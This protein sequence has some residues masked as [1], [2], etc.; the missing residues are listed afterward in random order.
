MAYVV[1]VKTDA[2]TQFTSAL[3]VGEQETENVS[4]AAIS[5]LPQAPCIVKAI[6]V[7]SVQNLA[8]DLVFF[9]KD[10]FQ[11][12]APN[13][14]YFVARIAYTAAIGTQSVTGG[15]YEYMT[16]PVNFSYPYV[17]LDGT[18]ELHVGLVVRG[19][20]AKLAGASGALSVTFWCEP[21][22]AAGT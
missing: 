16:L 18:Q 4:L 21:M 9:A 1:P 14:E 3:A 15:L 7:S 22:G 10:T 6:S 8:F 12:A 19:A 20:T 5:A 13:D 17:D 11:Q 2:T